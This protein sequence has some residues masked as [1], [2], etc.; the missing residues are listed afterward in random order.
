[1]NDEILRGRY[2]RSRAE[3]ISRRQVFSTGPRSSALVEGQILFGR[4]LQVLQV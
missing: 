1:M 4:K 3:D 2:T